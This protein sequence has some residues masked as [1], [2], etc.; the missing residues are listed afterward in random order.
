MKLICNV[1]NLPIHENTRP[2]YPGGA[3]E[4][5]T[6]LTCRMCGESAEIHTPEISAYVDV[7][8]SARLKRLYAVEVEG[9]QTINLE[10]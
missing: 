8:L 9:L 2:V 7:P 10:E 5:T 3:I 4:Q 1:C 6:L